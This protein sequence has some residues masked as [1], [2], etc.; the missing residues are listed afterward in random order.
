V[1]ASQNPEKLTQLLAYQTTIIREAQRC[2][3]AGWQGYD[4]TMFRQHA[5]NAGA[6]I[7]W[8]KLNNSLFAVTFLAQ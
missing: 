6:G 2:S 7:D 3:G 8:S 1:V 5:A 4:T